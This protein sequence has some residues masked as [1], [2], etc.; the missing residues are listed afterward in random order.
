MKIE[1]NSRSV[2]PNKINGQ[3]GLIGGIKPLKQ[4]QEGYGEMIMSQLVGKHSNSAIKPNERHSLL[5]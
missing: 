1:P 2:G 4:T 5:E 3:S